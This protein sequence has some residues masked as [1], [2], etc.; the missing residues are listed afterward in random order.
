[1]FLSRFKQIGDRAGVLEY[2]EAKGRM[3]WVELKNSLRRDAR[4][5]AISC[6]LALVMFAY[7]LVLAHLAHRELRGLRVIDN[8]ITPLISEASANHQTAV[9]FLLAHGADKYAK[10][11]DG[12]T[13]FDYAAYN[14]NEPMA[15]L[16]WIGLSA[17]S[18][19]ALKAAMNESYLKL[20]WSSCQ[21]L[22]SRLPRQDPSP[23][24]VF[25]ADLEG[26]SNSPLFHQ[27]RIS[28]CRDWMNLHRKDDR[29]ECKMKIR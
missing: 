14:Q 10:T 1:L 12:F 21:F 17:M 23:N 13:A 4:Q 22:L 25:Q 29:G 28:C 3:G 7:V 11:S 8:G 26:K 24:D 2:K 16:L 5:A 19:A 6:A 27:E 9:R 20:L 18:D 15:R